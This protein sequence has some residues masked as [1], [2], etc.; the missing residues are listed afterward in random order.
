MNI[1]L[2]D[3]LAVM[4][5]LQAPVPEHDAAVVDII[6]E[7]RDFILDRVIPLPLDS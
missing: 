5:T 1:E 2:T 4:V 6:L 7:H 3:R